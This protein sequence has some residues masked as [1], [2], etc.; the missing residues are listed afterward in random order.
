VGSVDRDKETGM[1]FVDFQ[2]A[3][4]QKSLDH[5]PWRT[6]TGPPAVFPLLRAGEEA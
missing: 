5:K 6:V 3:L 1:A 4:I 2:P